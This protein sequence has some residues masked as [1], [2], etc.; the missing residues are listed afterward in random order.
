MSSVDSVLVLMFVKG[1]AT[2]VTAPNHRR[3]GAASQLISIGLALA[4]AHHLPT[5]VEA[6]PEGLGLYL[7]HGFEQVDT[8]TIDLTPWGTPVTQEHTVLVRPAAPVPSSSSIS[9]SPYLTN[10]DFSGFANAE[11]KAF[12]MTPLARVLRPPPPDPNMPKDPSKKDGNDIRAASLLNVA[13]TDPTARFVKAFIPETY[14]MI[15]WAKWN[16]YLDPSNPP[17][18]NPIEWPPGP[19][20][21]LVDHI[22]E[23]LYRPRDSHMRGKSYF[24]MHILAVLPEYQRKGIGRKMLEWGLK[25]ADE[26]GVECWIDASPAGLG[27]YKQCG[28]KEVNSFTIDLEPYGGKPG[29]KEVNV[30]LIRPPEPPKA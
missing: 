27:L 12:Q 22:M 21:A 18:P 29:E 7:K 16:F 28:W 8:M 25:Q 6:T 11:T 10:A 24:F 4:D 9:I 1:L 19:N 15:G 20:L 2:L 5:Y 14:Q 23:A 3:K 17:Q 13:I 30:Q 26:L